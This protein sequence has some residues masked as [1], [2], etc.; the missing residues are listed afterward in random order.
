MEQIQFLNLNR[1]WKAHRAEFLDALMG[2]LENSEFIGGAKVE[3]FERAYSRWLGPNFYTTGCGN[4]TDAI[5]IAAQYLKPQDNPQPIAILPAM[6][7]VATAEAVIQAGYRVKLVDVTPTGLIDPVALE[8]AIDKDTA[9]L[10]PVH[11]FGQM[12]PMDKIG[13][14][15]KRR[16][17]RVLEDAAQAHGARYRDQPVGAWS[18]AAT[19]SFFP[20][21][22]LGAFGDAGAIVSK[23]K[24]FI[25][26][27]SAQGKHG[28]LKKYEHN[29]V[30][31]NSRLDTI[32]AAV[33]LVK[34]KYI[35]LWNEQRRKISSM[36]REALN[37]IEA[38]RLPILD[39]QA[40]PV[41]HLFVVR[42]PERDRFRKYLEA[43]GIP[44]G[45]HYPAAIH[46]LPAFAGYSFASE[47]FPNAE[48]F[49]SHGISL[50]M[51]PT[52]TV[53]EVARVVEVI[54]SFFR[55]G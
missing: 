6:T 3:E 43:S 22:N 37:D 47:G 39:P 35:D 11:L 41:H 5:R 34:L 23:E 29:V 1:L 40:V 4:G 17:C 19:F 33:L 8:S 50:P 16:G 18:D 42:V 53:P 26:S 55:K 46:Q 10:V 9:L 2:C 38:I 12:A 24:N 36:Y 44:T 14:I 25:L 32:Q 45:I 28:G 48:D 51:C 7:F 52:L 31:E 20:G 49:S 13:E 27:C 30:G 15:A 54:R 21:K